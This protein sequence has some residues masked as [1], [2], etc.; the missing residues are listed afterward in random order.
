MP[1]RGWKGIRLAYWI[2]AASSRSFSRDVRALSPPTGSERWRPVTRLAALLKL[3]P[4]RTLIHGVRQ[5]G[6]QYRSHASGGLR[7]GGALFLKVRPNQLDMPPDRAP[8]IADRR[9]GRQC[10][11]EVSI[12]QGHVRRP[13]DVSMRPATCLAFPRTCLGKPEVWLPRPPRCLPIPLSWMLRPAP[14]V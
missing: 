13:G 7:Q 8:G 4:A 10:R 12:D 3:A 5:L 14:D 6:S 1:S 9:V 2:T 11:A